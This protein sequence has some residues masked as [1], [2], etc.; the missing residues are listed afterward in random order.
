MADQLC[1]FVEN[2]PGKLEAISKAL[3]D[4]RINLRGI[5]MA[6][7]GEFGVVRIIAGDPDRACRVLRE[8]RFTVSRRRIVVAL[9]EDVPGSLHR[10]LELLSSRSINIEDCY[11]IVLGEGRQAAVVLEVEKFPEAEQV[12]QAAGIELLSDERI[13]SI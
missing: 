2:R 12:L 11:G 8:A 4:G 13:Y 1:V 9:I 6:S 5:S 3:S 10:V 7:A